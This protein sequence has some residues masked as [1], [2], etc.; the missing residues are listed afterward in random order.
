MS[1]SQIGKILIKELWF[2]SSLLLLNFQNILFTFTPLAGV[3]PVLVLALNMFLVLSLKSTRREA[4]LRV[5]AR[6]PG[7]RHCVVRELPIKYS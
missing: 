7:K 2:S 4:C 6:V 1:N 3:M 5:G